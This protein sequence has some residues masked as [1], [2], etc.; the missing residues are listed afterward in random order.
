MDPDSKLL[1]YHVNDVASLLEVICLKK[2]TIYEYNTVCPRSSD[3]FYIV[4]YYIKWATS[5][6][7]YGKY[8]LHRK[9]DLRAQEAQSGKVW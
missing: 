4:T 7:T 5:S 3:P 8:Q 1:K 2:K 9:R 6:W